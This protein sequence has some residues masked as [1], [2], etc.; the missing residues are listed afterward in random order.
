MNDQRRER[1]AKVLAR[2]GLCSRREAERWIAAGRVAVDGRVLDSPALNVGP[3]ARISVDGKPVAGPAPTRLWRYHK[4]KGLITSHRDPEGRPT[5]FE[6]LPADLPRLISV[7]RLDIASEGLLLL[8]NNG[9]LA[10]H[11]ELPSTAWTRRY[12][13][14]VHGSVDVAA[15]Q[16]LAQGVTIE[17]VSYGPVEARLDRVQGANAWIT[18]ALKE[19]KNREVRQ[20]CAHLG[21]EVTRLIRLGYGP[22]QLGDLARGAV[23][24]VPNRVLADQL[25]GGAA[26]FG[27]RPSQP[28]GRSK[29]PARGRPP[30][31]R[32]DH[33]HRRRPA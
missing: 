16:R 9:E 33:A 18:M 17:G 31:R 13:V 3:E 28:T 15:L 27:I 32:R 14:R 25:G 10:R 21:L 22:F 20:L 1:I 4:P 26:R 5:V 7:G 6:R 8:T 12:R 29:P 23:E 2:A 11:L 24:A 19:G 30:S